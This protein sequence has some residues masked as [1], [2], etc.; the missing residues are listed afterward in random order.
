MRSKFECRDKVSYNTFEEANKF[1]SV[2]DKKKNKTEQYAYF[3]KE[4]GKIHITSRKKHLN[5]IK[6]IKHKE[7]GFTN[8]D[9]KKW[10]GSRGNQGA[11]DFVEV[12]YKGKENKRVTFADLLKS[13][14]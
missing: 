5:K 14:D 8:E 3:C 7:I 1:L 4:C 12:L 13:E 2:W 10:T 6:P 11:K 9:R